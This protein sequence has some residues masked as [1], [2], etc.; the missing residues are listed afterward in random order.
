VYV[1]NTF[2]AA[3]CGGKNGMLKSHVA[4][5]LVGFLWACDSRVLIPEIKPGQAEYDP[6]CSFLAASPPKI[7][8]RNQEEIKYFEVPVPRSIHQIWF[9]PPNTKNNKKMAAWQQY[10]RDENFTYKMWGLED[11]DNIRSFMKPRNFLLMNQF[12]ERKN[13]WA[14]S[15]I[16]RL[17]ILTNFGGIYSDVDVSPPSDAKGFIDFSD[18]LPMQGL[19]LVTETN[20]RTIGN[21]SLFVCNNFMISSPKHPLMTYLINNL[22]RN[23][24]KWKEQC[25]S[26]QENCNDTAM[27]Q[28]GP[29]YIS[30]ALTGVL[31]VLPISFTHALMMTDEDK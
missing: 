12:M 16:L 7:K 24:K 25:P 13:Y 9:G 8:L 30:K 4:L 10:A 11:W 19:T 23:I 14:V 27:Y 29:F 26:D 3:P 17:E 15:D 22:E 5:I 20:G 2:S 31:T 21:S 28:T 18:L 1:K 6:Y